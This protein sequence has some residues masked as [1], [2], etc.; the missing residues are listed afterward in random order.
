[1]EE[2]FRLNI[3]FI[4]TERGKADEICDYFG[5][6]YS[7]CFSALAKGTAKIKLLQI[8]GLA[9]TEKDLIAF[10]LSSAD[11]P[12]VFDELKEHF[13]IGKT[14]GKGIAFTTHVNSIADKALLDIIKGQKE[15]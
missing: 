4:I 9:D 6:R 11:V 8:L 5:T 1:M 7:L 3:I 15:A 12:N 2:K 13:G 10:P 14:K